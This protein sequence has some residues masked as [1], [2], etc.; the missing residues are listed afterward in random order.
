MATMARIG[1][2]FGVTAAPEGLAP[3]SGFQLERYLGLWY[4][5]ARMDHSF[6][7]GLSSVTAEYVSLPSGAVEVINRG[8]D[9]R[10]GAWREAR[11]K[12][13][14]RGASDVGQLKVAF[15]WPFHGAYNILVIDRAEYRWSLVAGPTRDY[16]WVLSRSPGM[17]TSLRDRLV[18]EA[19]TMGFAVERLIFVAHDRAPA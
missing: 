14:F 3:I 19:S 11:G 12:A 6:E 4:E 5:I 1:S 17:E 10:H 9:D 15:F 18:G 8:Y 16:F 13:T 7:R 2:L